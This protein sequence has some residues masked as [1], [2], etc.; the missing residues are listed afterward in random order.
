MLR[1]IFDTC[2]NN[3]PRIFKILRGSNL[4]FPIRY[5]CPKK[6]L[7]NRNASFTVNPLII[8]PGDIIYSV[9]IGNDISFDLRLMET[10]KVDVFA[11]D[12]TPKSIRWLL[13]QS[14]PNGFRAFPVGLADYTG[15]AEFYLPL[16][17]NFVS[18]SMVSKQSEMV[19]RVKVKRLQDIMSEHG[20]TSIDLLKMDIEGSE[21]AVIEDII[22]SK[23][24]IHQLLIEF[25]HR[26]PE[27]G[28][29]KT[30]QA[31]K[32]LREAGFELFYVSPIGEEFSF[33]N[34]RFSK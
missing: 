15:E 20:H 1:L 16:N 6:K 12:P 19:E 21:Y 8:S 32:K 17:E 18:A 13:E 29:S 31:I 33:I 14:V 10:F 27:H 30:R 3:L 34:L 7:G 5:S 24:Q 26:F 11:F 25:H 22:K 4:F 2:S 9:G 23:I 28:I